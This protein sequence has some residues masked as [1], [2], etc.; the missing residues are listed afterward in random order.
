MVSV[1]VEAVPH[2]H[3]TLA[4]IR[5]A[6]RQGRRGAQPVDARLGA[7][8]RRRRSRLRGGDVGEPRLRR[9]DVHPA[10]PRQD[11]ARAGAADR[12]AGSRRRSRSTAAWTLG[13][14]AAIVDGRRDA[15]SW[16]ATPSSARPIAEAATRALRAASRALVSA[17]HH[18]PT[19][20]HRPAARPRP[21]R[22][23]RPDGRHLPRQLPGL[24]RGRPHRLAAAPRLD[25]SRHGAGGLPAAGD[26]G[27]LP[28]PDSRPATTT[29]SRSAPGR[30][31]S[32]RC[33]SG[34]TTR[35]A[36]RRRRTDRRPPA[37][38]CTRR[39]TPAGKPC[40]LPERVRRDARLASR[41]ADAPT[42][43]D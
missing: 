28:L 26:R 2:L 24:V 17:R 38:P 16:P 35:S 14:V 18:A 9:P 27:V 31:C 7:R 40:R 43:Y 34:S 39:W 20:R 33:A 10:Q 3:R 15:S 5:S 41:P 37:T 30:R 4:L 11:P 32:R 42:V 12:A 6:R 36:A 23:H 22:G 25:L 19:P 8:G 1:H 13:N 21:L 29:S